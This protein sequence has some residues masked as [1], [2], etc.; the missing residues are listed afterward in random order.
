MTV[1]M[2]QTA[3]KNSLLYLLI[4]LLAAASIAATVYRVPRTLSDI[5]GLIALDAIDEVV[6]INGTDGS[7]IV[8]TQPQ[9]I[10]SLVGIVNGP[11]YSRSLNQVRQTGFLY[12]FRFM[13]GEIVVLDFSNTG[14]HIRINGI[15]YDLDSPIAYGDIDE[16]FRYVEASTTR[17]DSSQ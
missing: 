7:S 10:R 15:W 2:R 4:G 3:R 13:A 6:M 11:S 8:C 1:A 12:S 14:D 16:W 9:L 5:A 17:E